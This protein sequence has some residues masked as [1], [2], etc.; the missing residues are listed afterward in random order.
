MSQPEDFLSVCLAPVRSWFHPMGSRWL[1]ALFRARLARRFAIAKERR[2]RAL[3]ITLTYSRTGET[4]RDL[5][6]RSKEEQHVPMFIRRL[7]RALGQTLTGKW[8][9]KLEFQ[10]DGTVHFHLLLFGVEWVDAALIAE[11]WGHGFTSVA[12]AKPSSV[13]YLSKYVAKSGKLPGWVAGEPSG[14][15]RVVACSPGFW[16]QDPPTVAPVHGH[17]EPP[18]RLDAYV[19]IG[20]RMQQWA[21]RTVVED[22]TGV[23]LFSESVS[24]VLAALAA[25]GAQCCESRGLWRRYV[26]PPRVGH[27]IRH[28]YS[29]RS[30]LNH[31]PRGPAA[32]AA[33]CGDVNLIQKSE[34]DFESWLWWLVRDLLSDQE[35]ING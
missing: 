33:G 11:T 8:L 24:G 30:S 4:P 20:V 14:S 28:V 5:W 31:P 23:Y 6:H 9:R 3:F 13:A 18:F 29:V 22:E 32:N 1:S 17:R 16:V 2:E 10:A 27:L 25:V 19:P 26:V 7:G 34:P 12:R 15:I 35:A 21:N